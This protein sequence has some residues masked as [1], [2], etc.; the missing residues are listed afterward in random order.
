MNTTAL[1]CHISSVAPGK[2]ANSQPWAL[3][4]TISEE[5]DQL[6]RVADRSRETKRG[7]WRSPNNMLF[8][9]LEVAGMP[10]APAL[11]VMCFDGTL[12][13]SRCTSQAPVV[14]D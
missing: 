13:M 8:L 6:C 11:C 2:E 4:T 10:G 14:G 5:P 7:F 1:C 9:S 3:T 12:D